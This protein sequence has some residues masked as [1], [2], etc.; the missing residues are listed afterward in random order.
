MA[1]K[2]EIQLLNQIA[3][4]GIE[5]PIQEYRFAAEHVGM[6][7]GVRDRLKDAGLKDWRFDFAWPGEMLAVEV[8]GG[9]WTGGRHTR[10]KGFQEDILK[11]HSAMML[12]WTVYRC[13]SK[14][15]SER[16]ALEFIKKYLGECN[17]KND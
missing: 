2:L 4:C 11:Y 6:G 12:G 10:G 7:K 3:S 5:T 16:K 9:A 17:V 14:I 15:I 1:S 8:E 13:E